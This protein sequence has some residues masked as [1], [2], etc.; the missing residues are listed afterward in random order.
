[1]MIMIW[2]MELLATCVRSKSTILHV[3]K[4]HWTES[5][6]KESR[7][8]RHFIEPKG[9]LTFARSPQWCL[10]SCDAC[11]RMLLVPRA[12]WHQ[13]VGY[14][15]KHLWRN[16]DTSPAFAWRDWGYSHK[17]DEELV[18]QLRFELNTFQI[19]PLQ[20]YCYTDLLGGPYSEPG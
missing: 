19:K 6:R 5:L 10:P 20:H 14:G 1:M 18:S 12:V 11:F 7:N 13:M 15:N 4:L 8:S 16:L 2:G 3:P 17:P 9:S